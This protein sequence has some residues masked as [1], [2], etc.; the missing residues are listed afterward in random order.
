MGTLSMKDY[1]LHYSSSPIDPDR[2]T[3]LF[4]HGMVT[5]STLWSWLKPLI[6]YRVNWVTYDRAGHGASGYPGSLAGAET[7]FASEKSASPVQP[8][9]TD[10]AGRYAELSA[11]N[12]EKLFSR[13]EPSSSGEA[14][15]RTMDG[16]TADGE[17]ESR[18][19]D[20]PTAD[21]EAE[22]R[23]VDGPTADGEAE[24]E[25]SAD[26]FMAEALAVIDAL[27]LKKV[28]VAGCGLGSLIAFELAWRH[29]E[30]VASLTLISSL[31]YLPEKDF[32]QFFYLSEQL[33][34]LDRDLLMEKLIDEYLHRTSEI[35]FDIFRHS[36]RRISDSTFRSELQWMQSTYGATHFNFPK[37]LAKLTVPTLVLHGADDPLI[38]VQLSAVFAVCIPGSRWFPISQASRL[39]QLDA[40]EQTAELLLKFITGN[41]PIPTT[42]VHRELTDRFR[43]WISEEISHQSRTNRK[44]QLRVMHPFAVLWNGRPI[45]GKWNQRNAKELLLYLIMNHGRTS[46]AALIRTFL[47]DLPPAQARNHL[48]VWISHLNKIFS[49][50]TDRSVQSILLIGED[51]IAINA[52]LSCDLLDFQQKLQALKE[53]KVNSADKKNHVKRES[54]LDIEETDARRKKQ[55]RAIQDTGNVAGLEPRL[56]SEGERKTSSSQFT[57][58]KSRTEG[59]QRIEEEKIKV[60]AESDE[61]LQLVG[62]YDPAQFVSFRGEWIYSLID[63]LEEEMAAELERLLPK[64]AKLQLYHSMRKMLEAA[65][66]IEP[67]D[68]YCDEWLAKLQNNHIGE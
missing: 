31:F 46:R 43:H 18:M 25:L 6:E 66:A 7:A 20:G 36:F 32:R 52:E 23:M 62:N 34:V 26:F 38:P 39:L 55:P 51:A 5:D 68:G 24:S 40:P 64:L 61:F 30:R 57:P 60:S 8:Y 54:G 41:Q 33:L 15:S 56:I 19:V 47:D 37:E 35:N 42:A 17:A 45:E 28:H 63:S 14:E 13:E 44:L 65:R 59:T 48:R 21:G 22:S 10:E 9:S 53:G 27:G 3:V 29:P 2:P 11:D 1:S 4:I 58:E 16:S 49:S 67:Y 50:S 12:E